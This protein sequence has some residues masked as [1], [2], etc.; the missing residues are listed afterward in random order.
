MADLSKYVNWKPT[1]GEPQVM[2]DRTIRLQ[3]QAI[4]LI[5]P[6]G[7]FVWNRPTAVLVEKDGI[8]DE[9]PIVD[10]TRYALIGIGVMG[11]VGMIMAKLIAGFSRD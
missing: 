10:A 3:A 1:I 11:V 4:S 5:T 6:F 2:G 8:T 9:V 7:G